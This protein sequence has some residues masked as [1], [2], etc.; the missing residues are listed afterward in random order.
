VN[1]I[2]VRGVWGAISLA[3]V[4]RSG[5]VLMTMFNNSDVKITET[6]YKKAFL[7][8]IQSLE[9]PNLNIGTLQPIL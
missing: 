3:F 6:L 5:L 1:G 9:N 2:D 7:K 8:D 4:N